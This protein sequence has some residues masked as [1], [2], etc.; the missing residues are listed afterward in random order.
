MS[1][2]WVVTT[3]LWAAA[4]PGEAEGDDVGV[5]EAVAVTASCPAAMSATSSIAVDAIRNCFIRLVPK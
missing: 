1:S 2:S 4:V 5:G 3:T